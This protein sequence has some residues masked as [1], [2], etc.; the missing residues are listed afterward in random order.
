MDSEQYKEKQKKIL[1]EAQFLY[2]ELGDP[3]TER[4]VMWNELYGRM[5]QCVSLALV[6]SV[7]QKGWLLEKQLELEKKELELE[8]QKLKLEIAK[9]NISKPS[10]N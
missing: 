9:S 4:E 8:N 5:H 1:E 3:Q 2:D 10:V 7:Q 6:R